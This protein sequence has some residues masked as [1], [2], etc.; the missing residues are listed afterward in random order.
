MAVDKTEPPIKVILTVA[1]LSLG[2]LVTLRVFFVSYFNNSYETRSREHIDAMLRGG[3]Y[4]AT[5]GR[6]HSEEA[7]RLGRLQAS[8]DQIARGQRPGAVSPTT[9]ADIAPLTGWTLAPREVPRAQPAPAPVVAPAVPAVTAPVAAAPVPA[10]PAAPTS[11]PVVPA[12]GA[13]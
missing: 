6:V 8:M 10:A 1:G 3:S 4:L 12:A 9:S 5:A 2:I 13:H 7:P 11:V